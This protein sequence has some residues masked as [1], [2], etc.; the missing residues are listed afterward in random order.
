MRK[1]FTLL[2]VLFF[3]IYVA[4]G[5]ATL[6]G[7]EYFDSQQHTFQLGGSDATINNRYSVV[8]NGRSVHLLIPSQIGNTISVTTPVYDCSNANYVVLKFHHIC[9]VSSADTVLI[10]VRDATL[11]GAPWIVIPDSIYLGNASN[12]GKSGF[13]ENSYPTWLPDSAMAMAN[14]NWW[15]QDFLILQT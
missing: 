3:S 7:S 5:Q 6:V 10:E 15:K 11:Y 9:K 2:C 13:N 4:Q 14:N 12:Y 8:N 1:I